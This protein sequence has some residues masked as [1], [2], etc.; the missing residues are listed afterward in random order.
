MSCRF[1]TLWHLQVQMAEWEAR[2]GDAGVLQTSCAAWPQQA[3]VVVC[4]TELNKTCVLQ[5]AAR[6]L[7]TRK[8]RRLTTFSQHVASEE[9]R[10]GFRCALQDSGRARTLMG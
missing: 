7:R 9:T 3:C 5:R 8:L 4:S 10:R 1:L 6:K 2:Y